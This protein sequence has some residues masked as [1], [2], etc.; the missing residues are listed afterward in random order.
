MSAAA[1]PEVW[2]RERND[3][4]RGGFYRRKLRAGAE[5]SADSLGEA[6]DP[7]ETAVDAREALDRVERPG[8][9]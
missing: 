7:A 3:N 6:L 1:E 5:G 2:S 8:Q 9:L 4:R